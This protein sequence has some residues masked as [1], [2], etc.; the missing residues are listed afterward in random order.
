[1]VYLVPILA[2]GISAFLIYIAGSLRKCIY[3]S[4]EG[5][6]PNWIFAVIWPILYVLIAW[7]GERIWRARENTGTR[8]LFFTLLGLLVLWPFVHWYWCTSSFS[9][10]VIILALVLS[11][12]LIVSIFPTDKIASLLL[13]PLVLWLSYAS[14]LNWRTARLYE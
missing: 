12:G 10:V 1:M 4:V 5:Q 9:L 13:L 2:V 6:P 11:I 7:V 3:P 8:M 14:I